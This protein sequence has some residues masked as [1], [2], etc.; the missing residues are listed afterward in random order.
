MYDVMQRIAEISERFGLRRHNAKTE[1]PTNIFE[2]E[3]AD[4][5]R[6]RSRELLSSAK[7]PSEYT[8]EDINKIADYYARKNDVPEALVKSMISVESDYDPLAV[9]PKGAMGLM[10]IMPVVAGEMEVDDPF[11]PEQ[12]IEAGTGYFKKLLNYYGDDYTKALAAYNAGMGTVDRADGVPNINET[13]R[14]IDKVIAT[15]LENS[16]K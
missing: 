2:D 11:S 13:K 6:T 3:M 14:Y 10:Q 7:D 1:T 9:S 16:K 12:N 5:E 8:K 15:Y 4:I